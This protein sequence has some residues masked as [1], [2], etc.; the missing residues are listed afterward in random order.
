[1]QL[2]SGLNFQSHVKEAIGK[3]RRGIGM[4]RYLSKYV[5][6]DVLDQVYQLYVRPH[7]DYGDIIYHKYDPKMSLSF[8]QRLKQTQY[9]AALALDDEPL[10]ELL[11]FGDPRFSVASNSKILEATISF[12]KNTKRFS[13]AG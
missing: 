7:L 4:I 12:I 5:S 2:D 3:A 11:L 8:T 1:M 6:R 13:N 10:C 9:Y